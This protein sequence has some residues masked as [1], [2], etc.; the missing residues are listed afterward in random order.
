MAGLKRTL[1]VDL[2]GLVLSTPVMV[3]S[4]CAGTGRELGALTDL[5][6]V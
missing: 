4:G 1:A 6:K 5:H 2:N 3:A